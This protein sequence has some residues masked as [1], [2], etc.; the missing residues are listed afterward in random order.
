MPGFSFEN[1]RRL[2]IKV[3]SSLLVDA[4]GH[5][6]RRWLAGLADDVAMLQAAGHELLIVSSG[7]IAIGSTVLDINTRRAKLEDLQAAAAA[8]QR[9]PPVATRA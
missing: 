9:K 3:G 5:V 2:V 4:D 1:Q 7:A 8:G 6:N